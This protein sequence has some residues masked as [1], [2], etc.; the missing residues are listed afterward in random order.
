M[1]Y[2]FKTIS[3]GAYNI[4]EGK[5]PI[6]TKILFIVYSHSADLKFKNIYNRLFYMFDVHNF[7]TIQT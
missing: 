5:K 1:G 4:L 7:F 3:L 2:F 6:Y